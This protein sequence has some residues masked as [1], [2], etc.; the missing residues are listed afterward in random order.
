MDLGWEVTLD[1]FDKKT[2]IGPKR[3]TNIIATANPNAKK[4]VLLTAHYDSKKMGSETR[5]IEFLAASDSAVPCAMILSIA[6]SLDLNQ[7][8]KVWK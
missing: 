1:E 6:K 3:F 5:D 2:V 4:F 8:K 7:L